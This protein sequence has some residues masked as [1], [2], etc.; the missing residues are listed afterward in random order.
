M[1]IRSTLSAF[2]ILIMILF[3]TVFA[4]CGTAESRASDTE[5]MGLNGQVKSVSVK[6]FYASIE[7]GDTVIGDPRP[8]NTRP[9]PFYHDSTFVFNEQGLVIAQYTF[10]N[11]GDTISA[12]NTSYSKEGLPVRIE[13]KSDTYFRVIKKGADPS[14]GTGKDVFKI[15]YVENPEDSTRTETHYEFLKW[16][17]D[18]I[19]RLE[20]TYVILKDKYVLVSE[21]KFDY[22]TERP[23]SHTKYTYNSDG[24]LRM[25]SWG[26][27]KVE[28]RYK[29]ES[30][31]FYVIAEH[32][33]KW[34]LN[35][36]TKGYDSL[37]RVVFIENLLI[38]DSADDFVL[39]KSERKYNP[40]GQLEIER[41]T[42]NKNYY[43][44]F[45]TRTFD[46]YY[47]Y[48]KKGNWV[49]EL[50]MEGDVLRYVTYREITYF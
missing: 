40:R 26:E 5:K 42:L 22:L 20:K 37:N 31:F 14:D 46:H 30:S 48:D 24:S 35:R 6:C 17:N 12:I 10:D 32:Y 34:A 1:K 41:N 19:R 28:Y 33:S 18:Y 23:K 2:S 13:I 16:K 50:I 39:Y 3:A 47:W 21:V 45:P 7:D 38:K 43:G 29:T 15:E 9:N 27:Y 44:I 36:V 8:P 11:H 4:G 49:K 25:K